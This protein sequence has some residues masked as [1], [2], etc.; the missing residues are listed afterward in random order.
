MAGRVRRTLAVAGMAALLSFA[1]PAYAEDPTPGP[2]SDTPTVDIGPAPES[3]VVD[4]GFVPPEPDQ[5]IAVG[6]PAP[7]AQPAD[8]PPPDGAAGEPKPEP[9]PEGDPAVFCIAASGPG[10]VPEADTGSAGGGQA[11]GPL[12]APDQLPRTGPAPLLPTVA[13]GS[14]LLLIGVLLAVAGRRP[15]A[16]ARVRRTS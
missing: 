4:C 8:L 6:E 13:I 12:S 2:A 16:A 10:A 1:A 3:P 14:W 15:S 9:A 11:A 7:G 5:G